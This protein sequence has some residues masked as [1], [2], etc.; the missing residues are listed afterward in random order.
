M[1]P[2]DQR[3][4]SAWQIRVSPRTPPPE[5][6]FRDSLSDDIFFRAYCDPTIHQLLTDWRDEL[7]VESQG[8]SVHNPEGCEDGATFGT[9]DGKVLDPKHTY[10]QTLVTDP[11][12]P[13]LVTRD[14]LRRVDHRATKRRQDALHRKRS[15]N[16][17]YRC[18]P[19]K[20]ATC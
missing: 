7:P 4:E 13:T 20:A 2:R 3:N 8:Q 1:L 17:C 18:R 5:Q 16:R 19:A 11:I 14:L 6:L 9:R 12:T 15:R 10:I